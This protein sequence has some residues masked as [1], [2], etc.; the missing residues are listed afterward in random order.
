MPN[1]K[2]ASHS[3]LIALASDQKSRLPAYGLANIIL[4][5]RDGADAPPTPLLRLFAQWPP[6]S[7]LAHLLGLEETMLGL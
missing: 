6:S 2:S 7:L 5:R 4:E 3:L 1:R